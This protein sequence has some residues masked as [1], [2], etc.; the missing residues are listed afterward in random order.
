MQTNE[1]FE[2]I[3]THAH[4]NMFD[5]DSDREEVIARSFCKNIHM[6]NV[7][8]NLKSSQKALE[9]ASTYPTG[10][11]A[12][13]GLHPTNIDYEDFSLFLGNGPKKPENLLERD[14]DVSSYKTLA[15][16]SKVAAIGEIGLDYYYK[17]KKQEDLSCYQ[18]RQKEIFEKQLSFAEELGLPVII[19]CRDA[20]EEMI[21]ILEK[22]IAAG[23][24]I[25]G[26][27]HCFNGTWLQAKKYLDIGFFIGVNGIIFKMRL[28]EEL[29]KIP[30]QRIVLETDCPFLVP[31]GA[32]SRRNE[33]SFLPNIAKRLA[34][35][36]GLS[37]KSVAETTTKN[38]TK[39]F[40]IK[41]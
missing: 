6:I 38:A 37:L 3:D 8:T 30:L 32:A 40:H 17:P 19:H 25:K 41:V 14:F 9:I 29:K 28:E 39:L 36:K 31:P 4:L 24:K 2:L 20:H 11:F 5:F 15:D 21:A 16:D 18:S 33:P 13:V 35:I 34:D 7:G 26:V 27:I 12:A 23:S 22:K 10:V 1:S